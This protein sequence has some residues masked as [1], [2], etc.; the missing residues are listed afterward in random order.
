M[1]IHVDNH[2]STTPVTSSAMPKDDPFHYYTHQI[3]GAADGLPW[4]VAPPR[5][6]DHPRA[7]LM[8]RFTRLEN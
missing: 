5:N 1:I 8:V 7:Q 6:W 4:Q 2:C 3:L